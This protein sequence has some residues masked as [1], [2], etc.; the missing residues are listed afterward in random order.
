MANS[1][2]P[3]SM[4]SQ[5]FIVYKDSPLGGAYSIFG[6]VTG[7][8]SVIDAIAAVGTANP[9][10]DGAPRKPVVISSISVK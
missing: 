3:N 6:K 4:G 10:G 1:G 5:F 7:G 9:K 2:T 8:L